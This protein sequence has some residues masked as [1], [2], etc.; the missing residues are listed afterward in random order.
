MEIY[1]LHTS[2]HEV[3]IPYLEQNH[4]FNVVGNGFPIPENG[5]IGLPFLHAYECSLTNDALF[6]NKQRH[7]S[8]D[9]G[10]I[11]SPT[12]SGWQTFQ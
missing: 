10:I 7:D 2:T 1:E 4:S 11:I 3:R 6:L 5:I 8:M 12:V 9:D